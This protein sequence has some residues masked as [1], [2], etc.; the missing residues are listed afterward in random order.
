MRK[1]FKYSTLVISIVML[2]VVFAACNRNQPYVNIRYK[3]ESVI[4]SPMKP[5]YQ[6]LFTGNFRDPDGGKANLMLL[7]NL[8]QSA[9]KNSATVLLGNYVFPEGL[10]DDEEKTYEEKSARLEKLLQRFKNYQGEL[11]M[12][13]GNRDWEN[14][15]IDGPEKLRNLEAFIEDFFE[16]EN[17]FL[18]DNTC[19]GPVEI[20]LTE[21]ITLLVFDSQWWLQND[22]KYTSDFDCDFDELE[23]EEDY[24][25]EILLSVRDA[26]ERN[27]HKQ[28][29]FASHHPL[30]S[31]GRYGGH[32]PAEENLFP[33]LALNKYLW[34]PLPGFLYTGA[35]K[36]MGTPQDLSHPEYKE[37]RQS[38]ARLFKD[39][40]NITYIAAHDY[41]LQYTHR[42]G[43]H[44]IVSGGATTKDY[45]A[46][47]KKNDFG[48]SSTGIGRLN[49]YTNGDVVLQFIKPDPGNPQGK[50]I[51]STK[52]YNSDVSHPEAEQAGNRPDYTDSVV[53]RVASDQ[54]EVGKLQRFLKGENYRKE[55]NTGVPFRV[56]DIEQE[57]GGLKILKR[58]GG[59]QTKS[60]RL[61]A[62]DKRQYV[63]RSVEKYVEGALPAELHG[64]V[65]VDIVQDGISQS[66]PY[67]ALTVPLLADAAGV[68]HTNPQIV[69]VPDDPALGIYRKEMANK[70][71]LY[72]E[73]PAGDRSDVASFGRPGDVES[74]AKVLKKLE[75]QH[76]HRVDQQAVLRARLLDMIIGD[77]DRHDDQWRWAEFDKDD[78]TIY[79][80]IPRDRDQTYFVS[81]GPVNWL[82]R[83]KWMQPKFQGF[84]PETRNTPGFNYNARY[85]DRSFMNQTTR[86]DWQTAA[87][88]MKQDLTDEVIENAIKTGLPDSI[89]ALSGEKT[90]SILKARRN[91][92]VEYADEQYMFLAK[93]VDIPGTD[94]RDLFEI[95]RLNDNETR[96]TAW[97]LSQKKGK[98]KGI[99]YQRTFKHNET[100]EIRIYGRKDKD[101]FVISGEAAK[102]IKIRVIGGKGRD[103]IIDNSRVRGWKKKTLVYDKKGKD[104]VLIGGPETRNLISKRKG[105]NKYDR[106]LFK[107]NVVLPQAYFGYSI[108][109]GL[110]IG[111]GV[112]IKRYN[113]RD[114]TFHRFIGNYAYETN[115]FNIR[116]TGLVSS[117]IRSLDLVIDADVSAPNVVGNFY[118]LGNDTENNADQD[119]ELDREYYRVRYHYARF[120]PMLR[121]TISEDLEAFF[122]ASLVFGKVERSAGRFIDDLGQNG[123]SEDI[124]LDQYLAGANARVEYDN[125]DDEKYPTRG[126]HWNVYARRMFGL[127]GY[128]GDFTELSSDLSLFL[129]FRKDP[130]MIL[131]LRFGGGK[132][133]GTYPFYMAQ[134]LGDKT[135]LRG[136][137]ANRF[138]GDAA[139][140]QNTELRLKLFHLN[141]YLVNGN[142][143]L[144]GFHD[145][146]RVWLQGENSNSWHNGYGFGVWMIPYDML[147]FTVNLNMSEEETYVNLRLSYLF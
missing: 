84:R 137:R 37:L 31:S 111:G 145:V 96:V 85:F 146:G 66:H 114:S 3:S 54:Y 42:Q 104:N 32:F 56:F 77:W 86:E 67:A 43:L 76:D 17:V 89:Y 113:F 11:M 79:K 1:Q 144:L 97:E 7:Q 57:H 50:I 82:V 49:F 47:K 45:T 33:L 98:R 60:V 127:N 91:H 112:Y 35:R 72:E 122:G 70:L 24:R 63:L 30:Y 132:N 92:I 28:I 141:T 68:Y 10:P 131:A 39:Y 9:S 12:I 147:T 73:R 18:P 129:S 52:L 74:T 115:A 34:V 61:E 25:R 26:L 78:L 118:G 53:V 23:T 8:M 90:I 19:P 99:F 55:W 48:Y 134:G 13:P 40:N 125:R 107:Y 110:F 135:N 130:R 65:A 16:N 2:T 100:K 22:S 81:Q 142:V 124:F 36:F 119:G 15:G 120:R 62:A 46:K 109:D 128:S 27:K 58:G 87:K 14:G 21:N 143:G 51:F 93:T 116:Y 71:Y 80:P 140:Y 102:G 5:G 103:T 44:H 139:F 123:L 108:D 105:V 75:N 117:V 95:E 83:R 20:D 88:K 38:L 64:T 136:F 126:I 106:E 94:D 59:Q 133:W 69:Y 138:S 41:N 6:V 101:K 4:T 121:K 29:I